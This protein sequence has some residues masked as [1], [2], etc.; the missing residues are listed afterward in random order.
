MD[1]PAVESRNRPVTRSITREAQSRGSAY[2]A[3]PGR[4]SSTTAPTAVQSQQVLGLRTV[5][6]ALVKRVKRLGCGRENPAEQVGNKAAAAH[7]GTSP[8]NSPEIAIGTASAP[9]NSMACR[10]ASLLTPVAP[11]VELCPDQAG[12]Q[13]NETNAGR[14]SRHATPSAHANA[15]MGVRVLQLNMQRSGKVAGEVRQLVAKKHLDVLLLQE[16]HVRRDGSS[17]SIAGLGIRAKVAA[18]SSQRPWAAVAL[19]NDLL[20][21]TFVSQLSTTH[22]VCAEV[23]APGFSFY[24]ASLYFQFSDEIEEHLRHLEVVFRS[25]RGKRL[26][27]SV[28]A[29]ARSSLWGPQSTDDRGAQLEDLIRSYGIEVANNVAQPPTYWTPEGASYIDV[30]LASASMLG[31]VKGWKVRCDWVTS[32]H[33]AVDISL[34]VQRAKAVEQ[35]SAGTRFDIRRADWERYAES[36]ADLSKSRLEGLRLESAEDVQ[37]MACTL[38]GVI[39][40]ACTAAMPR[41]RIFRKSNPWWTQ[42]LT[43]LKKTVHRQRRELQKEQDV[44]ARHQLKLRY[45]YSLRKYNR[46]VKRTKLESWRRYVTSNGNS[47]P[48]GFVYKL[49]ANKLQVTK[50]ISTLR[51]GN[52]YTMSAE[53][54]ASSLLE[55]HVPEDREADDT[56]AQRVIREGARFAPGTT[57]AEPFTEADVEYAV[58]S[59][60]NNKAPGPDLIEVCAIKATCKVIPGQLV[61]L[62]NGC[63][64]WGVFPSAWKEGSLRILLKSDDKDEKD[65]KSYRPICLLS[66]IGK[67]FEKLLKERL[68]QTSMAPG[69]I[70]SRQ[71]GFMPGRSTEDAIVELRRIVDA[72][73]HRYVIGLLFDIAGAFDNVW[74]P[75]VLESLKA[76]DCPRNVF[77]VIKNY[78]DNRRVKIS[79]GPIEVARIAEKGCPQGSTLGP[80]FWNLV[81]DGLLRLLEEVVGGRFV[82][83][84]DDLIVVVSAEDRR[85]LE[86][87][88]QRVV[89]QIV[90]WCKTA[91]LEISA[92]KTE[93]IVL[94]S[95]L[96]KRAPIGRRGG[97]RPDRKRKAVRAKKADLASRPP[98]IRIGETSIKFKKTVRYLGVNFDREMRVHTHCKHLSDKVG[99]LTTKLR[100]VAKCSWGLRFG[101][102]SVLYKSVLVPTVAFAAAGWIDLCTGKDKGVLQSM[103]RRALITMTRSYR[104][105]SWQSLCVVAGAVPITTLLEQNRAL[106]DLRKGNDAKIGDVVVPVTSG[107]AKNRVKV[108]A[109][110]MWQSSWETSDKGL[111]TYAF[112]RD[113]RERLAAKWMKPNHYSTQVLTGHGNFRAQ[114]SFHKIVEDETCVCGGGADTVGHF[115]LDCSLFDPQRAVL[116]DLVPDGEWRW[117]EAA[118]YFVSSEEAFSILSMYCEETLWLKGL[119]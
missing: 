33:R 5:E 116:R 50:V 63:L 67:L 104:T 96:I 30:T 19:C 111:T 38:T 57:D 6:T 60:K 82:A 47:E 32:D 14:P 22:C 112:F 64:Q 55:V 107:D 114:L 11:E 74:W 59:F 44:P 117:P 94:R 79:I 25:L 48:W 2:R 1:A 97:A 41:K 113:V 76:R 28:D 105:A 101:V 54:T 77:E 110:K 46:V 83:Y 87:E 52:D 15:T 68:T 24:V 37:G 81:F 118:R 66:V 109:V 40:D 9:A 42:E 91:K 85:T 36:L 92:K 100:R 62:F 78:F 4:A 102:L 86:I 53:E 89:D 115:L 119:E 99:S 26:L 8:A 72:C 35:G 61:R 73:E 93:A 65:P 17:Y 31:F 58:R 98:T 106:F 20:E 49:Q 3:A 103:Q 12:P 23:L 7:V 39:T 80:T 18:V 34:G 21:L 10:K 71:F 90:Q 88:S 13:A 75:S 43:N 29:N 84:A 51:R 108:E 27:V 56:P 45:R 16:P 95:S 70:S 69:R